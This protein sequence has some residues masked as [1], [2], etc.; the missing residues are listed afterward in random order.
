[1]IFLISSFYASILALIYIALSL[2]VMYLRV[3]MNVGLGSG[4]YEKLEVAM[5]T[6]ANFNEYIPLN[7]ILLAFFEFNFG[8]IWSVHLLGC[9]LVLSRL[10]HI[11]SFIRMQGGSS[12]GRVLSVTFTLLIMV[13]LSILNLVFYTLQ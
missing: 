4:G 7:I 6:H 3:S 2:Y 1:M 13:V 11:Y 8:V 10:I 9:A 12:I 5:R